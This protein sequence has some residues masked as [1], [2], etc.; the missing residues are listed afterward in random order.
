MVQHLTPAWVELHQTVLGALP[1]VPGATARVQHVVTGTP[2]GEV[3]Y[4]LGLVDGRVVETAFGRDDDAADCT[5]LETYDDAVR[6]ASGQLELHVE[7]MRG[8]VKM[9][10][11]TGRFMAV[12]ECLQGEP[13]RAALAEIAAATA[14]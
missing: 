12:L 13:Y 5:F 4:T 2:G 1:E 6:L 7:F 10:G 11:A 3:A 9:T 14:A 8:K